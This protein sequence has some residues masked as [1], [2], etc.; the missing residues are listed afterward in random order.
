ML[1]GAMV[2]GP[3]V[4]IF[5]GISVPVLKIAG[6]L[7]VA[8]MGWKLL[9]QKSNSVE[10]YGGITRMTDETSAG[11]SF[12]PLTLPLTVGPGAIATMIALVAGMNFTTDTV[13]ET[14][15][16]TVVGALMGIF[17]ISLSVFI[18]FRGAPNARRILGVNGTN[19]MM[20]LF[21][22]ILFTIGVQIVADGIYGLIAY[23]YQT[24]PAVKL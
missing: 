17:A 18:A 24:L 9:N 1:F 7:V 21:A 19:V 22:F 14:Q 5:F 12:Y 20:R 23:V 16:A 3:R 13:T 4:L 10:D 15:V 11:S 8:A 6:G 2:I